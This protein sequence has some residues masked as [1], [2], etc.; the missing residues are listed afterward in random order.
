MSLAVI[1]IVIVVVAAIGIGL[2]YLTT[3]SIPKPTAT[4][5]TTFTSPTP[6][7]PTT[8]TPP[9]TTSP[10][11]QNIPDKITIG[12]SISLSGSFALTG[13]Q[14]LWGIKAAINWVNNVY[15][16]VHICGKTVK[17]D[18]KYYDDQS[19]KDLIPSLY[20]RLITVDKVNFLFGPYGSPLTIAAA[21][22]AER[23]GMLLV[24]WMANSD[25]LVQ[26][27]FKFFVM[28]PALASTLWHSALDMVHTLDPNAT[29]AILYKQDEFN[30]MVAQGAYSK[31][32]QLGLRVV[33]FKSYPVDITDF[34]P[35]FTELQTTHP[36]VILICSHERDGML[37]M[38]QLIQQNINAK[39]IG[40]AVAASLPQFYQNFGKMAE[41]IIDGTHWTPYVKWSPEVAKQ[42]GY[43]WFG[44][45]EQEFL[46]L[47]QQVAG[48]G[49]QPSYH[50][51]AGFAAVLTLVKAIE[52][53]Q[54]LDQRAV[55]NAYNE[56]KLM[57]IY[58]PFQINATN[59]AQIG[60]K[61]LVGQWQAG[62]FQVVWPPAAASSRPVYPI[63]TWQEKEAG[64]L[65]TPTP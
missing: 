11:C 23:Y 7:I 35:L 29:V 5:T 14:G 2:Y 46:Q 16:G 8:T 65:A 6:T 63:P 20:E 39:L 44:P 19:S 47:F 1:A 3:Y 40:I 57:T 48:P 54:S 18:L 49:N 45:T 53:A 12:M 37:A 15:G 10:A 50:A 34:T 61:I 62:K 28:V 30:T 60:H 25:K 13:H 22:V 43:E 17:L 41:G 33:Y 27:G 4:P 38:Q 26:Q 51:A 9:L 52:L 31:A 56:L 55:R 59:G 21:P 36:S 58:G 64:A 42:M 24:S 32:Q